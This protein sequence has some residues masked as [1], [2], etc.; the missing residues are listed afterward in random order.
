MDIYLLEM[1]MKQAS[2]TNED[3]ARALDID[4]VTFYRKKKGDSDFLRTEIQ[5]IRTILNL[6]S[7]EV[8]AIFF[9]E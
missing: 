6:T 8:D 7:K 9:D 1:K 3:V 5:K 4:P 2:K